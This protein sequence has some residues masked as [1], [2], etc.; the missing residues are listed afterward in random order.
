MYQCMAFNTAG[1]VLSRRASLQ[2]ACELQLLIDLFIY[3]L[4]ANGTSARS[5]SSAVN[6]CTILA[7]F[8][9]TA[10]GFFFVLF[11]FVFCAR[12][13]TSAVFTFGYLSWEE[14]VLSKRMQHTLPLTLSRMSLPVI[15]L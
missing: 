6:G 15:G 12:R 11:C 10:A 14:N 7:I 5:E 8:I 3:L 9:R 4:E 2:F 1:A 13:A